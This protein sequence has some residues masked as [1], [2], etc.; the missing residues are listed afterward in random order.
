MT[1]QALNVIG[2]VLFVSATVVVIGMRVFTGNPSNLRRRAKQFDALERVLAAAGNRTVQIDW[3]RYKAVPKERIV[4]AANKHGWHHVSDEISGRSWLLT[5]SR[6]PQAAAR[7]AVANDS[8]TRLARE[9]A[10]AA[11][12]AKGRYILDTSKYS[13]LSPAKI[14]RAAAETGWQTVG[15]D[16]GSER[17]NLVLA[18]RGT[19][20]AEFQHGPFLEGESPETLRT[21]SVVVERAREIQRIKGFDPLSDHLLDRARERNKHWGKRFNRQVGLAFLYGFVGL[22]LLGVTFGGSIP[23][24]GQGRW[25]SLAI[26]AIVFALFGIAVVKARLVRKKRGAELAD[27]LTA[28]EELNA[29]YRRQQADRAD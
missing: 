19:V 13:D 11:P 28:Y 29:I 17:D 15:T 5:F 9:L 23:Q 21:D 2:I 6:D 12:D 22:F 10:E 24:A 18:R 1:D 4:Q 20:T 26:T 14:S 27:V 8:H 16:A 7:E 3:M 25:I